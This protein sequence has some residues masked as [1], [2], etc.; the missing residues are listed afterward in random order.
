MTDSDLKK[1]P[2]Y[3]EHVR[4]HGRMVPFAG[5]AMPVQYGGILSEHRAVRESVGI[6]DVSHMGELEVSGPAA[7]AFLQRLT[8]NDLSALAGDSSQYSCILRPD[9]G[10]LDDIVIY[11]LAD[12][13]VVVVNASNVDKI[14]EWFTDHAQSGADVR[15]VSD[16][17]ALI[18]VQGPLAVETVQSLAAS[19]VSTIPRFGIR[20]G[21]I[22]DVPCSISRTGYTGEDGFEIFC[23]ANHAV[24]I[25]NAILNNPV[26]PVQPCGLGARDTLRLESGKLLYGHDMDESNNPLEA[27]LNFILKFEKGDFVGRAALLR[28]QERGPA[29]RLVGF[30][31]V[32]RGIPRAGCPVESVGRQVGRVTS[33]SYVPTLDRNLGMAYVE[34]TL[35]SVGQPLDVMIRERTVEA[36]VVKMPFYRRKKHAG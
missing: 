36:K 15:N 30:E 1:T 29:Q 32:G 16:E 10:I 25:W 12:R 11:R 19:D 20:P 22:G 2:L 27:G 18:A 3:A 14:A 13:F 4:L 34:P 28:V 17:T 33:G 35:T 23:G 24:A 9:G 7:E 5:W 26:R 31:M 6:F 21:T 8:V